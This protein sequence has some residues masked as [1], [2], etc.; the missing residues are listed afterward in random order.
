[1]YIIRFDTVDV[2]KK[3]N[4][5]LNV[6]V[7]YNAALTISFIKRYHYIWETQCYMY[8]IQYNCIDKLYAGIF[9][10]RTQL[11]A[12]LILFAF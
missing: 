10:T 1:M 2:T 7:I 4:E 3:K 12:M 6:N 5:L 8:A 9:L 11:Y